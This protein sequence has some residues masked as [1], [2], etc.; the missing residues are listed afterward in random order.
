MKVGNLLLRLSV[1]SQVQN[2]YWHTV[3]KENWVFGVKQNNKIVLKLENIDDTEIKRHEKVVGNKS[4]Y[5][6]DWM[7]WGSRRGEHPMISNHE[8]TLLKKQNGRCSICQGVFDLY[9]SIEEDHIWPTSLGGKNV[10]NNLQLL[11]TVCHHVKT[12]WDRKGYCP[13]RPWNNHGSQ[14]RP[15]PDGDRQLRAV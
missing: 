1:K 11:H 8:A 12:S 3:G 14:Q 5:D 7:Y 9:D 2:M 10:N 13:I 15:T 4:W 6:G